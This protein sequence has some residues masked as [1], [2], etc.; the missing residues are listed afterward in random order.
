MCL[1]DPAGNLIAQNDDSNGLL[2]AIA[3]CSK[4]AD[5]PAAANPALAML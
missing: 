1:F 5:E 2:S 4:P 3:G